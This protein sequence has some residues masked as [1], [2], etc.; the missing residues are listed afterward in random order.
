MTLD[1]ALEEIDHL[2]KS[3]IEP[4]AFGDGLSGRV[5]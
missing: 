1:H 2:R 4:V 5:A 3:H